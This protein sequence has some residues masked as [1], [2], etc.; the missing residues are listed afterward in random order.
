MTHFSIIHNS[1]Y[2]STHRTI[3]IRSRT[4]KGR[5][6][7]VTSRNAGLTIRAD[8]DVNVHFA[9]VAHSK[10]LE[11]YDSVV[12]LYKL[13]ILYYMSVLSMTDSLSA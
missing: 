11:A 4:I 1:G 13:P 7:N 2:P 9:Q 12:L 3:D 8:V 10:I 6:S 5:S